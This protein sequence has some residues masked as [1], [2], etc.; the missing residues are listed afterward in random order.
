MHIQWK[1]TVPN[2][3]SL[4]RI[5]ILPLFVV[6]YLKSCENGN[7]AMQY[8]SFA[9]LAAS[10]VTDCLDGWIARRFNQ[11]SELGKLLDPIA[12]KLTQVAVLICLATQYP[13][14]LPILFICTVKEMLQG[15]GGLILL[16]RG[17][18]VRSSKWY[19][20][21]S[22]AVFY[23]STAVVVLWEGIPQSALVTL[24]ILIGLFM[25]FAFVQYMLI[26]LSV[27]KTEENAPGAEES[28]EEAPPS[29]AEQSDTERRNCG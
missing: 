23:A 2:I 16:G 11:I 5:A 17:G 21:I 24:V 6:L 25:L 18:A 10:G 22:T 27:S 1:W 15:V 3:L 19:G 4:I 13:A 29:A 26:F 9:L 20:K 28:L 14:F 7:A 12:D 8:S